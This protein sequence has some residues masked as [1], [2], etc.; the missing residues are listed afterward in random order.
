MFRCIE[1]HFRREEPRAHA[2]AYLQRLLKHSGRRPR[3]AGTP[4]GFQRLLSTARWDE[5]DVRDSV[6]AFVT[7]NLGRRPGVLALADLGFP[8]KGRCSAGVERQLCPPLD[9]VT[10]CQVGVFLL[11]S[12]ASGTAAPIDRELYLPP[13]W[14]DEQ[15]RRAADIPPDLVPRERDDIAR[16]LVERSLDPAVPTR[17]VVAPAPYGDGPH[18]RRTL[19]ERR[20]P[21]L[22]GLTPGSLPLLGPAVPGFERRVVVSG[23]P[24]SPGG[25]D[26]YVCFAPAG[27]LR[28]TV[29]EFV[30]H[31]NSVTAALGFACAQAGLDQYEVR[32]WRAWYRHM[33]LA[34]AA[35]ACLVVHQRAPLPVAA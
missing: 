26:M 17:G 18:L 33:T 6:R 11:Y 23:V 14:Q 20:V 7:G 28:A 22:L 1:K 24:N 4:D 19:E 31:R 29:D 2:L 9:R 21:Y 5:D 32:K 10:N 27:S 35:H 3:Y 34:M 12:D 13:T 15:R 8:K 30:R 25:R 16:A